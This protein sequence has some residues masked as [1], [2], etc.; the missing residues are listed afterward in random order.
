MVFY[1]FQLN[2]FYSENQFSITS[3]QFLKIIIFGRI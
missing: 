3:T 2:E 1:G